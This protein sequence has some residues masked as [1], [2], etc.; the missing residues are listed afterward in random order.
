MLLAKARSLVRAFIIR[1]SIAYDRS[2]VRSL[3]VS[4]DVHLSTLLV[5]AL[6]SEDNI[7]SRSAS[8]MVLP[9]VFFFGRCVN[10]SLIFFFI[11]SRR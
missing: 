10:I 4:F 6:N 3:I 1:V 2:I 9:G 11:L 8:D 5:N 7:E